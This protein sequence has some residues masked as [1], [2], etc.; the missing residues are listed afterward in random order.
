MA[1]VWLRNNCYKPLDTIM[2][3]TNCTL[4]V[5]L[6]FLLLLQKAEAHYLYGYC[7]SKLSVVSLS[8]LLPHMSSSARERSTKHYTNVDTA[9]DSREIETVVLYDTNIFQKIHKKWKHVGIENAITG[10]TAKCFFS[11]QFVI[12]VY[13]TTL[14]TIGGVVLH[15]FTL[16][17]RDAKGP[18]K[19]AI[20]ILGNGLSPTGF[21]PWPEPKLTYC[22]LH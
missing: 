4:Y 10:C 9:V 19:V 14:M 16:W 7:C 18:W 21:K 13:T 6:T 20:I 5:H 22:Q 1:I 12:S 17:P 8:P 3:S 15:D 2:Y 11:T